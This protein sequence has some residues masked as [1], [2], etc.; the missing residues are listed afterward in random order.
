[1]RD[2]P[3]ASRLLVSTERSARTGHHWRRRQLLRR[4]RQVVY[5]SFAHPASTR[6]RIGGVEHGLLSLAL[7]NGLLRHHEL[8]VHHLPNALRAVVVEQLLGGV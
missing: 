6:R 4:E 2:R 1:M 5:T 3:A 8:A 7:Q